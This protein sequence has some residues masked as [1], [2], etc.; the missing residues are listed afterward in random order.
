MAS[1]GLSFL[2]PALILMSTSSV[3]LVLAVFVC[4]AGLL[5]ERWLFFA[6]ARHVV[7]FFQANKKD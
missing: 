5:A 4:L 2:I 3:L 7:R 1:L 6:E